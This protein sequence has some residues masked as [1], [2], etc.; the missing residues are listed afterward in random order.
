MNWLADATVVMSRPVI[1]TL[2]PG[3]TMVRLPLAQRLVGGEELRRDDAVVR[4]RL[5]VIVEVP[6]RELLGQL[7]QRADVVAV[8]VRGP[9]VIDPA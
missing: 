1:L 3:L 6:D 4:M 9:Q 2:S 7:E 8:V 5:A